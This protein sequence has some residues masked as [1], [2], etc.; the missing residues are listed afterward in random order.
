MRRSTSPRSC[1]RAIP[2]SFRIRQRPNVNRSQLDKL[3]SS[4][5]A[6]QIAGI[7]DRC[8]H[9]LP[10]KRTEDRALDL[11]TFDL[12]LS[13]SSAARATIGTG[14]RRWM[15]RPAYALVRKRRAGRTGRDTRT[16]G[17]ARSGARPAR[18]ARPRSGWTPG[19]GRAS[20]RKREPAGPRSPAR[21]DRPRWSRRPPPAGS[22]AAGEE[23][24]P[25]PEL[26][27]ARAGEIEEIVGPASDAAAHLGERPL[28]GA[29]PREFH[30]T[31]QSRNSSTRQRG[32]SRG[33]SEIGRLST[34]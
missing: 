21:P 3:T 29:G 9:L 2:R 7:L 30:L 10:R 12:G 22:G 26:G 19:S 18:P 24:R 13:A 32:V 17:R 1:R 25:Q 14:A 23:C 6:G 11:S 31:G 16:G 4:C 15:K 34:Y 20:A 33:D 5:E 28:G 8:T 27:R